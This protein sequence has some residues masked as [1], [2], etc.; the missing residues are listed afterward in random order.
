MSGTGRV[1]IAADIGGSK[2]AA[3]VVDDDGTVRGRHLVP[4]PR[5]LDP[6]VLFA[7]LTD[8]LDAALAD[9]GIPADDGSLMPG[10]GCSGSMWMRERPTGGMSSKV[11]I[12]GPRARS[13]ARIS[14]ARSASSTIAPSISTTPRPRRKS[15]S[16][17]SGGSCMIRIEV[18]TESGA[19]AVHSRQACSTSRARSHGNSIMPAYTLRIGISSNSIATTAPKLPPPPRSAQ[20]RSGFSWREACSSRPSAVTTSAESRRLAARPY[21]RPSQLRPP[22]SV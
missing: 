3:G 18:V 17:G 22:P 14:A 4:K 5:S 8:A 11:S 6:D 9:A 20:K 1:A 7:A 19:S 16:S 10:I 13:G 21:L 15:G 2:F 12:S